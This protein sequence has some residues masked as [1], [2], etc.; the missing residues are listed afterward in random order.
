M[1]L[2]GDRVSRRTAWKIA[3]EQGWKTTYD[4]EYLAVTKLQADALVTVNP[5]LATMAKDLVP[6][7]Q[8]EALT[9]DRE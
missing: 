9:E 6:L 1:R 2:L 3:R 5:A 4:A 7:A 8:L